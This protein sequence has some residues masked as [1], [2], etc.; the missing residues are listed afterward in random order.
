[1]KRREFIAGLCGVVACPVVA[2]AQQP[3][4]G[5]RLGVLMAYEENDIEGNAYLSAFKQGLGEL[6]WSEGRNLRMD[7]R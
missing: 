1:M 3:G 5:R 6:G 4:R 7:V 2:Q